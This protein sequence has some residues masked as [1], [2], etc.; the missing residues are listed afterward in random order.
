MNKIKEDYKKTIKYFC[1]NKIFVIAIILVTILS[2]G[3]TITNSS[4]GMDDTAFDRYYAGKEM[5]AIGRWGAYILYQILNITE[6]IPF[7]LDFIAASVIMFTSVLWCLFLK[8]NLKEKL[9]IGAYIIFASVFISFP[10]INEI[11]IFENCNIAVMLGTFLASLGVMLFYENYNNI[12]KKSI[13]VL[14]ALI[15]TFAISM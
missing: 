8:K 9:P 15:L 3:F 1:E 2:F 10:I 13:Y 12:H 11:F 6:F 14:S 7:W 4:V 5:L